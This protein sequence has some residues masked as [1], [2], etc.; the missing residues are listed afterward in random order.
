MNNKQFYI[1]D[2]SLTK[3]ALGMKAQTLIELRDKIVTLP[4]NSLYTH[5]WGSRLGTSFEFTEFHND[6]SIWAHQA[7]HDD[8]LSERID[9]INPMD[10]EDLDDLRS[11]LLEVIE[12]RLEEKE[13]VPL[14][15]RDDQFHFARSKILVF[16]TGLVLNDPQ[17][18]LDILPRLTLSSLFY[19]VIDSSLRVPGKISDFCVWLQAF[20]P[21]YDQLIPEL[22]K[23]DPYFISLKDLKANLINTIANFT[24]THG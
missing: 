9:I 1:K 3:I 2:C 8:V 19:H 20:S 22:A 23:V 18:L 12:D 5:F 10:Y 16:D 6:F 14:S 15:R 21:Q 7:L 13:V 11:D 17:E 24:T 4:Q